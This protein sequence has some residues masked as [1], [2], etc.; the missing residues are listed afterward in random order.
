MIVYYKTDNSIKSE[1]FDE[2]QSNS[3]MKTNVC[4]ITF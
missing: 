4:Q 2:P 1:K 3:S